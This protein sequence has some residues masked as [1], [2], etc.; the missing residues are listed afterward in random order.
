M[1][2]EIVYPTSD[3]PKPL[4][5][6]AL[7]PPRRLGT[8]VYRIRGGA[9]G[10][11]VLDKP[12]QRLGPQKRADTAPKKKRTHMGRKQQSKE[13]PKTKKHPEIVSTHIVQIV[14]APPGWIAVHEVY[15]DDVVEG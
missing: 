7:L 11:L 2:T 12:G 5:S 4:F 13:Q 10:A 1:I 8:A 6:I 9:R 3:G 15:G 14:P